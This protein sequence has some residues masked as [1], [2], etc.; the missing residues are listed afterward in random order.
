MLKFEK[1]VFIWLRVPLKLVHETQFSWTHFCL[2]KSQP[3]KKL[4]HSPEFTVRF[5][6]K[7][8]ASVQSWREITS[9]EKVQRC[10]VQEKSERE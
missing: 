6:K 9:L 3:H 2:V 8:W 7:D 4:K 5:S 1:T 10:N